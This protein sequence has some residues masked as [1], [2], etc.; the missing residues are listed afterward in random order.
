MKQFLIVA[1]M[2]CAFPM[3]IWA[4]NPTLMDIPAMDQVRKKQTVNIGEYSGRGFVDDVQDRQVVINDQLFD[5]APGMIITDLDGNRRMKALS[6]GIYVYY[7]LDAS[8]R[9]SKIVVEE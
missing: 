7:F 9:L 1:I 6:S 5:F 3:V 2:I 4:E 8:R